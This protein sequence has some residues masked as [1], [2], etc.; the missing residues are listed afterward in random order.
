M[1]HIQSLVL[2]IAVIISPSFPFPMLNNRNDDVLDNYPSDLALSDTSAEYP[3]IDSIRIWSDSNQ[4]PIDLNANFVLSRYPE[5]AKPEPD[6]KFKKDEQA[7]GNL[8]TD[9]SLLNFCSDG[10][11]DVNVQ[12]IAMCLMEVLRNKNGKWNEKIK[13]VN[14]A[15]WKRKKRQMSGDNSTQNIQRIV[16]EIMNKRLEAKFNPTGW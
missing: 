7:L 1:L 12:D 5:V 16:Q 11:I 8:R 10:R 13:I 4:R 15:E 14:D 9:N 2:T 6:M 3:V